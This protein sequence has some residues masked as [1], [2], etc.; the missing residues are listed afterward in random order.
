MYLFLK[1][2]LYSYTVT[3][4]LCHSNKDDIL[5]NKDLMNFTFNALLLENKNK[6]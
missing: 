6:T 5:Y 4:T 3:L 1:C 2:V